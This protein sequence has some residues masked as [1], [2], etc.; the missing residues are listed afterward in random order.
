L[1]SYKLAELVYGINDKEKKS[2]F[3][4]FLEST[5]MALGANPTTA[6]YNAG[7]VKNLQRLE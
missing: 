3:H 5:H 6:T 7:V 2:F 1:A 4:S